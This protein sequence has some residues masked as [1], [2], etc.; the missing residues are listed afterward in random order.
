MSFCGAIK[1]LI[2]SL[3]ERF[4]WGKSSKTRMNKANLH[5]DKL[6]ENARLGIYRVSSNGELLHANPAFLNMLGFK[7]VKELKGTGLKHI[8]TEPER[9][10]FFKL[11]KKDGFVENFES[12]WRKK[13][14]EAIMVKENTSVVYDADGEILYYEGF[15]EDV[16]K[17]KIKEQPLIKNEIF[18]QWVFDSSI[19]PIM[20][21]DYESIKFIELNEAAVKIYGLKSRDEILGKTP[22]HFSPEKQYDGALSDKKAKYYISKALNEGSVTF[23]WLHQKP[24]GEL[25]DAEIHLLSFQSDGKA[26]L[27]LSLID[28]TERKLAEKDL[29]ES[30]QLFETLA[31]A[32]PVGIFRTRPDGY[33]T[34]VNPK[35]SELSGLSYG[36]A[37]GNGWLRAVHPEDKEIL[38]KN[39]EKH[40]RKG[41]ESSADYRF[42]KP[43]GSIVWVL[44]NAVPEIVDNKIIGYVG[45]ITDITEIKIAE[46]VLRESEERYRMII[47][48]FPDIIMISDLSKNIIFAND[49]LEEITGI[50]SE[51]YKNPNRKGQIHPDDNS[52]VQEAIIELL[53]SDKTHTDLI[54]NRF[55]DV[56]GNVHWFSGIVSKLELNNQIVLQ[57]ITRD[58][59]DK[60]RVEKELEK[61]RNKL[62]FLVK[63]RT[64]ELGATND[65][66]KSTNE[67]LLSQ[68]EELEI[69]LKNLRKAQSQLLQA[70]KMASLGILSSGIAHEINNPLN[71][72]KAG[73]FG[74]TQYIEEN[75]PDHWPRVLPLIKG[76][77]V[78]ID[79]AAN[80]VTSLNHYSRKSDIKSHNCDIHAIIDNC[81]VMLQSQT[82]D[83]IEIIKSFTSNTYSLVGNEGKLHQAVL[84]ILSNAVQAISGKGTIEITTT[85]NKQ[86]INVVIVDTGTGIQSEDLDKI[87]DPF[88]TTKE[89][90]KGTGLGLAITYNTVDEHNGAIEIDS[91]PGKGTEVRIEL[92]LESYTS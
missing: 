71:F 8:F 84:N 57:T 63:K 52:L 33:T 51:D 46:K 12:G 16:T 19:I 9:K 26:F 14:G 7:S 88:F 41:K 64:E 10:D 4:I 62:E 36:E 30:Q 27:Q 21:M 39:W 45:T 42:I 72:I 89:V 17:Q 85:L 86:S 32:S 5:Y 25:W 92:P 13:N 78:G 90:G 35:W 1:F 65:E 47:E 43:D 31:H 50:T 70:E 69:A 60:K 29:R 77:K 91:E 20:V 2:K 53:K 66:L 11:I 18:G 81:L 6:F 74:I 58:I 44:G 55:I 38:R 82:K 3:N 28:V 83:R 24:N 80:I 76:M 87:F 54:E 49:A 67:E 75:L 56:W 61:Y 22:L 37:I 15:I 48:A 23:E 68:R 40:S 59:T 79:R 34:Y 73:L